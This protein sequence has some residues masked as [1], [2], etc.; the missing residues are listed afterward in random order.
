MEIVPAILAGLATVPR[1][2]KCGRPDSPKRGVR[3]RGRCPRPTGLVA[4]LGSGGG[5]PG[6]VLGLVWPK[7]SWLLVDSN[8]RRTSW[9]QGDVELGISSRVEV[10]M[11]ARRVTVP[12]ARIPS[13]AGL[14]TARRFGAAGADGGM[15]RARSYRWAATCWSPTRPNRGGGSVG[16]GE[17]SLNSAW[18]LGLSEAARYRGRT[19]VVQPDDLGVGVLR[20][21]PS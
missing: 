1:A 18:T 7:A 19:G 14:V 11:R 8:G 5:L 6:L 12:E 10:R 3:R 21:V 20:E 16:L 9:L 17:V 13:E 2:R 4:D 15:R